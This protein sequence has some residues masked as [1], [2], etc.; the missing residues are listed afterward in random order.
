MPTEIFFSSPVSTVVFFLYKRLNFSYIIY[1]QEIINASFNIAIH[2]Q[3]SKHPEAYDKC[4]NP[5]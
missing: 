4:F 5:S 2:F 1:V 3:N